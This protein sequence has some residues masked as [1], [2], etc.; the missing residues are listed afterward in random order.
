[1]MKQR[2][3]KTYPTY[4]DHS[5]QHNITDRFAMAASDRLETYESSVIIII[6]ND[7]FLAAIYEEKTSQ[8]HV[9]T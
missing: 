4:T 6:H 9:R 5:K 8:T 7:N 2:C 3:G 1:M